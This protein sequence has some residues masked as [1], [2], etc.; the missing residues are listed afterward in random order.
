MYAALAAGAYELH[1][2]VDYRAWLAGPLLQVGGWVAVGG[3]WLVGLWLG[4]GWVWWLGGVG[5]GG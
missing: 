2:H 5:L 3:W 4:G 1:D